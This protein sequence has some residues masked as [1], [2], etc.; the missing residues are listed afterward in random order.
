MPMMMVVGDITRMDTDAIVNAANEELCPGGGVCGAIFRAAGY[1]EL[2]RAC[3][4]IGHCD[5]GKAV[6]TD[7]FALPARYIIHTPGPV[8][9]RFAI[10]VDKKLYSCYRSSLEL[11]KL[12]GLGSIAF[13]LISSGIYGYPKKEAMAIAKKAITDFLDENEMDVYIVLYDKRSFEPDERL[14]SDVGRYIDERIV[15]EREAE[16]R[17]FAAPKSA[18]PLRES[19]RDGAY[20]APQAE[21]Q[22]AATLDLEDMM[23]HMDSTF[24]EYLFY[25]IDR[26]GMTD[27]EVYKRANIDRKLFSKIKNNRGYKPK[28]VTAVAFAVALRLNM[29]ELRE[30]VARAGYSFTRSSKFDI[31]IEYFVT[32]GIY[33]IFEINDVLFAFDQQLIGV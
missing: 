3:S 7:G 23:A 32:R 28:K 25:L 27:V 12:Y 19:R 21:Y 20:Y 24:S 29:A 16:E 22:N 15:R 10:G 26:S 11:A 1:E 9:S 14:V 30:L 5:T 13:P 4:A 8:Y 17:F 6:I 18:E 2:D 33:D 31:I